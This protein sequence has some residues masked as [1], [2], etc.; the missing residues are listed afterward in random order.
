MSSSDQAII[1]SIASA[2]LHA[3]I[4][5]EKASRNLTLTPLRQ[6]RLGSPPRDIANAISRISDAV[7]AHLAATD[8]ETQRINA[9]YVA[10]R[11]SLG[12]KR[13]ALTA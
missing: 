8:A 12:L 3:S 2:E 7:V 5:E 10:F 6:S 11:R 13:V 4:A 9:S 1:S